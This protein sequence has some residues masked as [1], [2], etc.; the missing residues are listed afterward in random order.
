MFFKNQNIKKHLFCH[1]HCH[2]IH[3]PGSAYYDDFGGGF[4]PSEVI[5]KCR[6]RIKDQEAMAVA[7]AVNKFK[8]NDPSDNYTTTFLFPLLDFGLHNLSS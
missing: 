3:D 7:V 8:K 6:S 1:C 5:I 4:A 2:L